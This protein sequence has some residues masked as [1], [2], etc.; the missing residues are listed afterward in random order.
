MARSPGRFVGRFG[1]CAENCAERPLPK[2]F[3]DELRDLFWTREVQVSNA[4]TNFAISEF[5][6]SE[7]LDGHF[8]V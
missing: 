3:G 1:A 5:H 6:R 2:S 4:Y 7:H 8:G